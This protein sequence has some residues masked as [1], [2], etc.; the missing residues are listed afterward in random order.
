MKSMN[1]AP[2]R[3]R[4]FWGAGK[5]LVFLLSLSLLLPV[6]VFAASQEELMQKIDALSKEL[7]KL[8]QQMEDLKTQEARKEERITKVE[9]KA[10]QATGQS[11][12]ELGGDYRFRFDSLRGKVHDYVQ[13]T[14]QPGISF[15]NYPMP[16]LTTTFFATGVPGYTAKNDSL[17][18]N[19]FGLNLKANAT[20]DITVKARLLMYKVWG[21]ETMTPV[22]GNFFADRAFGPFD[23][24]VTHVPSDNTLRVDYAYATWSNI[25]GAP[26]WFSIGRRPSTGGVPS[27]IRQNTERIGTAG[28]PN[29][30]VDYA[31]DG[32]TLGVAPDIAALPGA[33]AKLCYGRGYDSGFKTNG[34]LFQNSLKDTDFLGINVVPYDTD[35]LHVELQWQRGW[36]IF[37]APSDGVNFMGMPM[38][39]S[40]NMGDISWF[41]GVIM[42]K[43][44]KLG[45][46][47]LNLFASAAMSKTHPNTNTFQLPFFS[48]SGMGTFNGGFGLLYDDDPNTLE[49][50]KRSHT[51]SAIYLGGRYDI[52]ATGTKIGLEYNHGTKYWIGMVPAG[53]D[54]WTSKLGTRGDVTEVYLIQELNKKPIA[55]R[56]K[57]FVRIG[58]QYYK[59]NYT[60]SNNWVGEPKKISELSAG[61]PSKTQL[62]APLKNAQDIYAT[63]DVI[64]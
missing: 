17:L 48:I 55:K 3:P 41:G 53:D 27:N 34:G 37:N 12:L 47:D 23:G 50:D 10:A 21:H 45:P 15:P 49:V 30:M 46:G 7:Q 35:N 14:G 26:I 4:V 51:G 33:Y 2:G 40:L 22:E 62:F 20:E 31:F 43:L 32:L 25:G 11:W 8:K 64:F 9:E 61:D 19:R 42:G 39:V 36:N 16:G 52:K 5:V 59:F 13:Y 24:T 29:I 28:I 38:P 6:S 63:F 44:E 58:Y 1:G 57:A 18:L 56:G 54:L 60:G